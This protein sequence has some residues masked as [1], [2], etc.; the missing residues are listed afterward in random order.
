MSK[1]NS[2]AAKAA[3]RAARE[4][5]AQAAADTA[6]G[7]P[8]VDIHGLAEVTELAKRGERMP[9]GCDAH[10]MLHEMLEAL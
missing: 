1:R 6:A 5:H 2:H 7:R 4:V 8:A 10:E 3:R 9:C